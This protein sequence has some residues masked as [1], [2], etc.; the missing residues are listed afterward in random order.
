[1]PTLPN[2]KRHLPPGSEWIKLQKKGS[3]HAMSMEYAQTLQRS[4]TK[5]VGYTVTASLNQD[6]ASGIIA[7]LRQQLAVSQHNLA[8]RHSAGGMYLVQLYPEGD[9]TPDT[10]F[11]SMVAVEVSEYDYLQEG[12][13]QHTLPAGT[14]M[15]V[16]HQ[17]PEA[18]IDETYHA[19]REQGIACS[20][21][22][23]FEYWAN[24][25]QLE[26]TTSSIDI[27]LPL[28]T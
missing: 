18:Q 13:V 25:D 23:D 20:R 4:E 2:K 8:N 15:K 17:G 6:I 5:L 21:K 22:F 7:K 28:E 9:W 10:P 27:Y 19:I 26:R 16:T 24:A 12:F 11:I 3:D 14:Y 1:M